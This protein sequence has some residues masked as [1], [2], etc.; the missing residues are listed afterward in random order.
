MPRPESGEKPID[1]FLSTTRMCFISLKRPPGTTIKS[2]EKHF[3][4]KG[5]IDV[6][7]QLCRLL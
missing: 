1:V 6:R 5:L 2:P 7:N 4:E 3:M